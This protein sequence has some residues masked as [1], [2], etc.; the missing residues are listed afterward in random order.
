MRIY[1]FEEG[2]ARFATV[3]YKEPKYG[4]MKNTYMHLTNYAI[5]KQ[6]PGYVQNAN[7]DG[8]GQAHKKRVSQIWRDIEEIEGAD[9]Q[10]KVE[11]CKARIKDIV[12]KTLITGQPAI[13]HL[14]RSC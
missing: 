4:N 5:N 3:P 14:Y 8:G 10:A 7:S 13:A 6:N 2:L 11:E 1:L 9:G 12:I